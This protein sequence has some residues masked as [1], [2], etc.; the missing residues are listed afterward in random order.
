MQ[1]FAHIPEEA[2]EAAAM[3]KEFDE[4]AKKRGFASLETEVHAAAG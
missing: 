4:T 2:A 1:I 3:A